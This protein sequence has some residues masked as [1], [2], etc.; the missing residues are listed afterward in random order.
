MDFKKMSTGAAIGKILYTVGKWFATAALIW[1]GWNIFAWN[2]NL[3]QFEYIEIFAMSMALTCI[4]KI[5]WQRTDK[6]D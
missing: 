4:M 6:G 1:W 5:F 2:F 3:P